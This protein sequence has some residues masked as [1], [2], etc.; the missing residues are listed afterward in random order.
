MQRMPHRSPV[1]SYASGTSPRPLLGQTIG[2][3]L[4]RTAARVPDHPALV[5]CAQGYRASYADLYD[6]TGRL[7]RGLLARGV[8]RGD[9]VGIWSPNR[10]EWVL[11]QYAAARVG[12]ILVNLNPAYKSAELK[13]ALN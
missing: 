1:G 8:A 4:R 13:Y 2:D 7:A 10:Y 5:V 3:N 11:L 6:Q 12:A 9:R